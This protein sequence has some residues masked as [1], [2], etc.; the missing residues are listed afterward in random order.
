[1]RQAHA[2]N[3]AADEKVFPQIVAGVSLTY[4]WDC[5]GCEGFPTT[6]DIRRH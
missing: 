4:S 6:G 5:G 1:M 3:L 2:G